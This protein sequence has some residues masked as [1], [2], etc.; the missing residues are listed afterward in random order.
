MFYAT[1]H[2]LGIQP[3]EFWK[4]TPSEFFVLLR[5]NTPEKR[6]GNLG[7]SDLELLSKQI[8]TGDYL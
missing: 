7:E 6:I 4:M 2:R 5:A 3:S 8:N 1:A